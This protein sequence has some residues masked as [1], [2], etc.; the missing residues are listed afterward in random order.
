MVAPN[1]LLTHYQ[2]FYTALGHLHHSFTN[3]EDLL[4][5]VILNDVQR[6]AHP[7][8]LVDSLILRTVLPTG[9]IKP[10]MDTINRLMR[11]KSTDNERVAFIKSCFEQIG[12]IQFLRNRLAH[13]TTYKS[14]ENQ[15]K[16]WVNIDYATAKET[17]KLKVILF[18][19]DT[20]SKAANDLVQ[21]SKR[22]SGVF[23]VPDFDVRPEPWTYKSSLLEH[24]RSDSPLIELIHPDLHLSSQE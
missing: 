18:D 14:S 8:N 10:L 7:D 1:S 17:D 19:T 5:C 24:R 2:L 9:R 20:L 13:Y 23:S 16:S 6:I 15:R 11:I 4:S 22:I 21:I 3:I 12:Q